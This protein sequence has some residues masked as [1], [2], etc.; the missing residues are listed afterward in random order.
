[1]TDEIE[2]LRQVKAEIDKIDAMVDEARKEADELTRKLTIAY[3]A[4]IDIAGGHDAPRTLARVALTDLG[5][6]P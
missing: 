6:K 5:V 4:L 1:M 2:F 3:K